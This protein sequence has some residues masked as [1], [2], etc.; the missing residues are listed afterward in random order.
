MTRAQILFLLLYF[1]KQVLQIFFK[2][3]AGPFQVLLLK[4]VQAEGKLNGRATFIPQ[5]CGE[6]GENEEENNVNENYF[7]KRFPYHLYKLTFGHLIL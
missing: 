2:L 4:E 1:G 7:S 3:L 6:T 5:K